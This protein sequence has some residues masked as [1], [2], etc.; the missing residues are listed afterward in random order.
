MKNTLPINQISES[1]RSPVE[2][3]V[4]PKAKVMQAH[5]RGQTSL[6]AR[7][8]MRTFACQPKGIE[9]FVVDRLDQLTQTR[10][11]SSPLFG[12]L[13][14]T[15]LVRRSDD[16]GTKLLAPTRM[17]FGPSK[18]FVSEIDTL[19]RFANASQALKQA[20]PR[21]QKGF[22]QTLIMGRSRTEAK[23]SDGSGWGHGG[24]QMK[25]L[26]P[27]EAVTPPDIGLTWQPTRSASLGITGRDARG[28]DA[29]IQAVLSLHQ[30]HQGQAKGHRDI[31]HLALQSVE[32]AA[33]RQPWKGGSQVPL[34]VAVKSPFA[35]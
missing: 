24:E 26:V 20:S 6:E 34:S 22:Q 3:T 33:M 29:L 30:L 12:P 9:Q 25:A 10:Q 13:A 32:L 18:P 14:T 1:Q 16:E 28:V 19:C 17:W 15:R 2:L 11:P 8:S 31:G 4:K 7:Q 5:L 21:R 27:A 23:T 35:A